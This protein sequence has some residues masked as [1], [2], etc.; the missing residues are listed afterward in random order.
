MRR[1]RTV[2]ASVR[3]MSD[4]KTKPPSDPSVAVDEAPVGQD[5]HGNEFKRVPGPG[6]KDAE[7]GAAGPD[8]VEQV[9]RR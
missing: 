6:P 3:T 9:K 1:V 5:T 7:K 8:A 2:L 4:K